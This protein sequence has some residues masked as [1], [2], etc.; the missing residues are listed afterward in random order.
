MENNEEIGGTCEK[1][2]NDCY[3]SNNNS[4]RLDELQAGIDQ[5]W[6]RCNQEPGV[7]KSIF[8]S[9]NRGNFGIIYSARI[10]AYTD[11]RPKVFKE[12]EIITEAK[13]VALCQGCDHIIH[14]EDYSIKSGFHGIDFNVFCSDLDQILTVPLVNSQSQKLTDI[15][16]QASDSIL[17]ELAT[18]INHLHSNGWVHNNVNPFNIYLTNCASVKLANFGISKKFGAAQSVN[19]GMLEYCSPESFGPTL[20]NAAKDVWAYAMIALQF[21]TRE[22]IP[23]VQPRT[24]MECI[25]R[26]TWLQ[27][28]AWKDRKKY[29]NRGTLTPVI[30][31]ILTMCLVPYYCRPSMEEVM[32]VV[33]EGKSEITMGLSGSAIYSNPIISVSQPITSFENGSESQ[34][35]SNLSKSCNFEDHAVVKTDRASESSSIHAAKNVLK[36]SNTKSKEFGSHA[37][38]QLEQREYCLPSKSRAK[39]AMRKR[40]V[41]P[42]V[43]MKEQYVAELEKAASVLGSDVKGDQLFE[44]VHKAQMDWKNGSVLEIN[45]LSPEIRDLV[46][47]AQKVNRFNNAANKRALLYFALKPIRVNGARRQHERTLYEFAIQQKLSPNKLNS[48]RCLLKRYKLLLFEPVNHGGGACCIEGDQEN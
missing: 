39:S 16:E 33:F 37:Y 42:I 30:E 47:S 6:E 45:G 1:K 48:I 41:L 7:N 22:R 2:Q 26:G 11:V 27:C 24:H 18:A 43:L 35:L 46:I 10:S 40:G 5:L 34:C 15:S 19:K 28:S 4:S 17:Y 38:E 29:P 21:L 3:T 12:E 13:L 14:F 25:I 23:E 32:S 8:K 31:R 44:F 9:L 36:I 20:V